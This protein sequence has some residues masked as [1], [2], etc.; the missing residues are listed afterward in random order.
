MDE[1]DDERMEFVLAEAG[2]F[3]T[4]VCGLDTSSMIEVVGLWVSPWLIMLRLGW[5]EQDNLNFT[6]ICSVQRSVVLTFLSM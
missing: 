5:F 2:E 1:L 3:W 4:C 6:I